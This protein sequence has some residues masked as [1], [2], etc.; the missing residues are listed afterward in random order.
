MA[1]DVLAFEYRGGERNIVVYP[2]DKDSAAIIQGSLITT[3][4]ATAGFVQRVDAN[5][6]VVIGVA[7]DPLTDFGAA[8][9]DR[10]IRV[11]ISRD[12]V[13]EVRPS[14][15]SVGVANLQKKFDSAADGKTVRF[16]ATSTVGDIECVGVSTARNTI[17]VRINPAFTAYNP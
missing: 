17:Q 8:D 14:T 9:G 5:G 7:L 11:D 16:G 13:Y 4:G 2:V 15:G 12:S 10:T 1:S 6:E 3:A